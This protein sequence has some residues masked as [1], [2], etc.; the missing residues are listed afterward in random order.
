MKKILLSLML[1][2]V[3]GYAVKTFG[4]SGCS[5]PGS[6]DVVLTGVEIGVTQKNCNFG[7]NPN[8]MEIVFDLKFKLKANGGNKWIFIHSYLQS[9]Y[10]TVQAP[11]SVSG[12]FPCSGGAQDPPTAVNGGNLPTSYGQALKSFLNIGLNN[13][14]ATTILASNGYIPDASVVLNSPTGPA[15][16]SP[17]MTVT[18]TNLPVQA[19]DSFS[20]KNIRVIINAPCFIQPANVI[21]TPIIVKTD[22]WSTNASSVGK[23]Q[24]W[25][26]GITNGFNDPLINANK[27]CSSP[28][29][30]TLNISTT[31]LTPTTLTY[32][33]YIDVNEDGAVNVGD[34]QIL[35][36]TFPGFV[37][38]NPYFT[39]APTTYPPYSNTPGIA[40]KPLLFI[41]TTPLIF[42]SIS[43]P[44][45]YTQAG[46]IALPVGF[47]SFT[48][49]RNHS[50]VVV[51]W[52]TST[53]I[54]NSGFAVERNINGVWEQ[55]AFVPS[56]ATNGTSAGA[57]NY[58]FIDLNNTKGITQYRIRQVDIDGKSKNSDIR[59]VRGEGQ[60]GGVIIYPNPTNDGKVNIVFEDANI[61]RD[62]AVMD[63]SGRTV[64]QMRN[65]TN[66]NITIENLTPGMY[67]VRIVAPATGDQ[68]VQKIVVNKR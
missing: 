41:A 42:N 2:V 30:Y 26:G 18:K 36:G 59:A 3:S 64:K 58:Q 34:I 1:L 4:Q 67:T 11:P 44:K 24:C 6:C 52:E 48:A 62:V 21:P 8:K 43:T 5:N 29:T 28:R 31:N 32:A 12:F 23:A 33:G 13:N 37:A 57:L 54:N 61:T 45:I 17:G 40:E 14:G 15:A 10:P 63:M 66:N 7:G 55:I 53:E 20:L 56:Q 9:D 38:G 50:N 49:V 65:V 68:I 60:S 39:P 27:P 46:C 19:V 22:V 51:K 16:N 47:K 25:L 35:G